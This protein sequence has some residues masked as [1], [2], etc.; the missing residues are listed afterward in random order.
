MTWR[1]PGGTGRSGPRQGP[2]RAFSYLPWNPERR[3]GPRRATILAST[4]KRMR[5]MADIEAEIERLEER[6]RTAMESSHVAELDALIDDRLVFIG[7]DGLAYDKEDDLGLHRSGEQRLASVELRQLKVEVHGATA[8]AVVE[9]DLQ[10]VFKGEAF[11]GRYRYLRVWSRT[12]D[13]WRIIAGSVCAI[14]DDDDADG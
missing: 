2:P 10:G 5:A 6:L 3:A 8:V 1:G 14:P 13:G 9:A 4:L 7:P 11:A 12:E